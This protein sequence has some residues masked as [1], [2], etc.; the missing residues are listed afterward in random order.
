ML[1]VELALEQLTA[2]ARR[3][4]ESEHLPPSA[5]L[6]RVLAH[7][8]ISP[9]AVPGFDNSAMDGYALNVPDFAAPPASYTVTQR[10]AAGEVGAPLPAGEAARIFTGAAIPPGANAV[11]MQEDCTM[12]ADTLSVAG[13]I[14]PGQHIRRVGEDVAQDSI[15]V[16]AG[17]RLGA[18]HLG[19]VASIGIARVDVLRPL[20][21]ALLCTGNELVEPGQPL[22]PGQIYNSNRYL[23]VHLLQ[24]LGC[25]VTDYGI[26][27]DER[28]LTTRVLREAAEA[29]DV[30]LSTGGVSVGEEDHV[31]AALETN[32]WLAM[33][34]I[35]I[36]PGKPFAFGRVGEAD[37]IGLPGNPVST[38]VTF[39][40]LVRPFLLARLGVSET[41]PH[42]WLPARF[43]R[44]T[45]AARREY[46]R[47]RIE[48][49]HAVA[50]PNQ[51]SGVL[52]SAAW[53]DAL[54][55]VPEG[56]TIEEGDPVRILPLALLTQ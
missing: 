6:G 34:K 20:R 15:V 22:G 54:A 51:S 10:I 26:V 4:T 1:S 38:F 21:V 24:A 36:K 44:R 8:V 13:T 50:Y 17:T 30:V 2:A 39:V 18:T 29:H 43:E 42:L 52:T 46:L 28:G 19:L 14:K 55:I 53:A 9:L 32:A 33:W 12:A 31:R 16:A 47:V 56:L 48:H 5:A 45:P 7:D 25:R 23:L 41:L 37:F 35:A 40:L 3:I 49:G 27:A 11:V